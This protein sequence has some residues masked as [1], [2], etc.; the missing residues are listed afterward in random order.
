MA[1]IPRRSVQTPEGVSTVD[2]WSIQTA[3]ATN[4]TTS[5]LTAATT[6]AG[7]FAVY[8][9]D[10]KFVIAYNNGGTITYISIPLDGNTTTWTHSSSAP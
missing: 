4:P 10:K 1:L 9:R 8:M 2:G 6:S 5:N 7:Q 3:A